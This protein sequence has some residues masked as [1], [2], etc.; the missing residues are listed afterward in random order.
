MGTGLGADTPPR[1]NGQ[2]APRP[3]ASRDAKNR[4]SIF[5][6]GSVKEQENAKIFSKRLQNFPERDREIE[7]EIER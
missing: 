3:G 4:F 2:S 1:F 5:A 6:L 7:R